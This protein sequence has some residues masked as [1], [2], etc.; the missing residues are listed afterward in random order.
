MWCSYLIFEIGVDTALTLGTRDFEGG[1]M[2]HCI[3]CDKDSET[4]EHKIESSVM[5]MI[6]KN[7]PEWVEDDGSCTACVA[8]YKSLDNIVVQEN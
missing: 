2:E 7:N 1:N 3:L 4:L 5:E 8:Y 6:K